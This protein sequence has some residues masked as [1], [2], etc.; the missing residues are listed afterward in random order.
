[1]QQNQLKCTL[2]FSK[3]KL[4]KHLLRVWAAKKYRVKTIYLK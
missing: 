1:M 2:N 4:P 3:K